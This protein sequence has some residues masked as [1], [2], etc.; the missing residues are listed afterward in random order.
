MNR[1]L[2]AFGETFRC[3]FDQ[4]FIGDI[5]NVLK[6]SGAICKLASNCGRHKEDA[7][8]DW[9]DAIIWSS[10]GWSATATSPTRRSQADRGNCGARSGRGESFLVKDKV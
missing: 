9:H 10:N 7:W 2:P 6:F 4:R 1:S 5:S 3:Y 8:T